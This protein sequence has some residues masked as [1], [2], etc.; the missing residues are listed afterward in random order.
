VKASLL[1]QSQSYLGEGPMWHTERNSIFW[2]DIEGK[3]FF[4]YNV[5]DQ[6]GLCRKLDYRV[7]FI[8][9]DNDDNLVLGL[10]GGIARYNLETET[11]T[12]LVNVEK[13]RI[14]HRCNDGK[15]DSMGRLWLGT[16]HMDFDKGAGSL[17]SLQENLELQKKIGRLTIANGLAWSLN[18]SRLYFIDSPERKVQSFLFDETTGQLEFEKDAIHIPENLGTPDGMTIDE[19]GMLWIAHWGGFGVYRWNPENGELLTKIEIPVPNVSSCAFGGEDL[20]HLFITTAR[21]DLSEQELKDYPASGDIF[22]VKLPVK[23]KPE[24]KFIF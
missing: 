17:Y 2:V 1:Y 9:R 16:L 21:Q 6:T 8:V 24:N 4:E 13:D 3:K 23:G 10:E 19:E 12:W 7:S 14:K 20:D 18:N 15:V 11:L 5:K 22:W